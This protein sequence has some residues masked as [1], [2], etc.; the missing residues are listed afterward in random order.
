MYI[1]KF[2]AP[3][4]IFGMGSLNQV[5]ECCLRLGASRV[6]FVADCGVIQYKWVEKTLPF[7]ARCGLKYQVWSDFSSNPRDYEVEE[8]AL[9]YN[10]TGCDAV[11]AFGGGSAIDAAK[12]VA[13]LATNGGQIRDYEGIDLI[14]K[15]LPPLIVIPSTAGSGSEVSQFSIIAD[16]Q[17]KIKMTIISK[18]LVPDIDICDPLVLSTINSRVTAHTGMEALSHAVEAYLSLAATD[19]TDLHALHAIKLIAGNLRASVASQV[20]EAAK[21]AMATASLHAGLAFSNAA[22][23]LAHAMTHQVGGLLDLPIGEISA[24]LLPHVMRFNMIAALD[25]YAAIARAMGAKIDNLTP[26]EA[27]E[28]AIDMVVELARDVG[29]PRGLG[30]LNLPEEVIPELSRNAI[31]DACFITNPR[32]ADVE[33]II[34]IFKAAL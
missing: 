24:V 15:P 14:Q 1:S 21:V 32:D 30:E 26:R 4:I 29:I 6:F 10:K 18:S 12:A 31:K 13:T 7:L 27:A 9:L 16:S 2:V 19:I 34:R 8:G 23:G 28:K 25:K 17:R 22:L 20:N 33:D 11:V 3:E 5:G